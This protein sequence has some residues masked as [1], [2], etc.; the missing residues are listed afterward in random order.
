MS[1]HIFLVSLVLTLSLNWTAVIIS[2]APIS[3]QTNPTSGFPG[4]ID[5]EVRAELTPLSYTPRNSTR[6]KRSPTSPTK[7][8]TL[9][10]RVV[11]RIKLG[12]D[13]GA[14][15]SKV[16]ASDNVIQKQKQ[17]LLDDWEK[18]FEHT[19]PTKSKHRAVPPGKEELFANLTKEYAAHKAEMK[20]LQDVHVGLQDQINGLLL[21]TREGSWIGKKMLRYLGKQPWI[22][23]FADL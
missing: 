17:L 12:K 3:T 16:D 10:G 8:N 21:R 2:A 14:L 20:R 11:D 18:F 1:S 9:S 6:F 7:I 13:W 19:I 4:L 15:R 22:D 23:E 5:Y